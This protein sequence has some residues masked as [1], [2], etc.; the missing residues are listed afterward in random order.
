MATAP[1][2]ASG[3]AAGG[4]GEGSATG[5][6][7]HVR[8]QPAAAAARAQIVELEEGREQ[9][10][11]FWALLGAAQ[12]GGG[13][14]R[15][16]TGSAGA[17][18]REPAMPPPRLF[19]LRPALGGGAGRAAAVARAVGLGGAPSG[20]ALGALGLR[21]SELHGFGSTDLHWDGAFV[22]DAGAEVFAW[23]GPVWAISR[24]AASGAGGAVA[25]SIGSVAAMLDGGTVPGAPSGL[26]LATAY[27]SDS[28]ED[29]RA[30][31]RLA[32]CGYVRPGAEP[33]PFTSHF[34]AWDV[35][36]TLASVDPYEAA[37]QRLRATTREAH[38]RGGGAIASKAAI[39]YELQQTILVRASCRRRR[40]A[41]T[42]C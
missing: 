13:A 40:A 10:E 6:S 4:G 18:A 21:P 2:A 1:A 17:V 37:L 33:E 12:R 29:G 14:L 25:G 8:S 20:S 41:P 38:A 15:P 11:E 5:G 42:P 26:D 7:E 3:A 9:S 28:L 34:A 23:V 31:G 32:A 36:T 16:P 22:L 30:Y 39:A 24:L 35:R 27:L 19:A